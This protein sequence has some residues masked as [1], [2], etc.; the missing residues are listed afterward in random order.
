MSARPNP[1]RQM[2]TIVGYRRLCTELETENQALRKEIQELRAQGPGRPASLFA[3]RGSV[4]GLG[5]WAASLGGLASPR[6][7]QI[8]RA[9]QSDSRR[10]G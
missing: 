8:P 10:L 6:A 3:P 5:A 1:S 9:P 2:A 7:R 4:D